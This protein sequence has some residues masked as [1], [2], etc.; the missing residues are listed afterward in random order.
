[1][2]EAEQT[3]DWST[4]TGYLPVTEDAVARLEGYYQKHPNDRVAYAQLESADPW[5]WAPT[6]FRIQRDVVEPRLEEAVLS[7]R[8]ARATLEDARA[9]ARSG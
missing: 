6:L 8:D 1:M 2:C 7:N 3:I 4:R 9:A 5:P